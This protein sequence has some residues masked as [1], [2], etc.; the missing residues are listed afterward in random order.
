MAAELF[1]QYQFTGDRVFLKRLY[2]VL[3]GASEFVFDTL[4]ATP[5][6]TL[7]VIPSTSPENSYIHPRTRKQLRITYASTYHMSI[8]RAIFD[9]TDS[10][11]AILGTDDAMRRRIAV[12]RGKLPPLK[13]GSDGR[14]LEW[15]EPYVEAEPGHRHMSHLMGLHPFDLITRQT[16]E[17]FAGARKTIDYRLAHGGG[18]TGWSRAWMISFFARLQDGDEAYH[19]Y[20]ELLRR[21]TLPNLFD[22]CPPF[23][24][25]GN[26]GGAAGFCEMLLQSHERV[27]GSGPAEQKF[28]IHLL[29]ALPKAWP[30]GSV[31]GLC[32][33]GG[34]TV[35]MTWKNGKL[36]HAN[37]HSTQDGECQVRGNNKVIPLKTK[38]GATYPLEF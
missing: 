6:G 16:P 1:D 33:R 17:L 7:V 12:A 34:F 30:D 21:S 11:A 3:Q 37:I 14:I 29:P 24:I 9:A 13:L 4:V 10:A 19:H 38:C 20:L 5:D 35:D 28:V 2:P 32:A 27:T 15:A 31:K 22:N 36:T 25:D 26:F 18:G 8:V 23:Q